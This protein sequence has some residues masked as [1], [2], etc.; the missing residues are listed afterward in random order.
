VH[1]FRNKIQIILLHRKKKK[2][3]KKLGKR[4]AHEIY[5][6]ITAGRKGEERGLL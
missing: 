2:K 4:M 5:S 3:K 6:T 1:G